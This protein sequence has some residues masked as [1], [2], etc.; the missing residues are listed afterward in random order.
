M[1]ANTICEAKCLTSRQFF[2]SKILWIEK[3]VENTT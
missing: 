2:S 1:I 3:Y